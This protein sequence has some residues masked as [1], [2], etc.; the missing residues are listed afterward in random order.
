MIFDNFNEK[1]AN[2]L[3]HIESNELKKYTEYRKILVDALNTS[4]FKHLE[5][6]DITRQYTYIKSKLIEKY[7]GYEEQLFTFSNKNIDL[8]ISISLD[9]LISN[10]DRYIQ[11]NYQ[12][13]N[14]LMLSTHIYTTEPDFNEELIGG[15]L[16]LSTQD[17][18]N[19]FYL[20][21]NNQGKLCTSEKLSFAQSE[22]VSYAFEFLINNEEYLHKKSEFNDLLFLN[23]D[24]DMHTSNV[25]NDMYN[26]FLAF[27]TLSKE[28]KPELTF[29]QKLKKKFY[30]FTKMTLV[31][32][33]T[34]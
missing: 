29:S 15:S 7:P 8:S 33:F 1:I 14:K 30:H 24:V 21:T 31:W 4:E 20:I 5:D 2:I 19:C 6:S 28:P 3:S 25:I 22:A 26:H 27:D 13:N 10:K 34:G 16:H 32:I 12:I 23:Y 18:D 17:N 9:K 11:I